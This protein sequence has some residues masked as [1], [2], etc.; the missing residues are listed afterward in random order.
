M[1]KNTGSSG[2]DKRTVT[3][4]PSARHF[5][6]LLALVCRNRGTLVL[7]LLATVV[8][9]CLHT[10]SVGVA[11][12][13]FK[14]LLEDE[15]IGG[16][17]DRTIAGG[18]LGVQFAPV[19]EF[20]TLRIVRVESGGAGRDAGLRP[21]D[22]LYDLD[23]GSAADLL[24]RIAAIE[25]GES[26]P[27]GV[28]SGAGPGHAPAREVRLTPGEPDLAAR[29]MRRAAAIVPS[30]SSGDRLR[31]LKYLLI[32]LVTIVIVANVFRYLGEV[33]IIKAVVLAMLGLRQELY[34]HTLR[35][36]LSYYAGRSTADVVS[37][38]VTDIQEIQR[39]LQTLFSKFLREPLRAVF[40]LG[41]AF[42]LDW[43]MTLTLLVV[44]P[45]TGL[46]FWRVGLRVKRSAGKLLKAYGDMVDALTQSLHGLRVVKTYTA[47]EQER[48]RLAA[49]DHRVYRQQLKLGKLQAFVSP[50]MET[51]VV[52]A[53][54]LLTLWL[55]GR[56]I[57]HQMA[58][59]KFATLGVAM[60]MLFDPLRK[61][62]DVYVR[63][64]RATAGAE[65]IFAVLDHPT[66][67]DDDA[68]CTDLSPLRNEIE[69]RDVSF[70][71]RGAEVPALSHINLTVRRGET[72]AIVGPNGSG[73]T[74]LVSMLPRL[75]LPD[76]GQIRYDGLDLREASLTS[77]RRQI[78]LVTQE[79]VVFA[80][81][82]AENIAYG[83]SSSE[84][85]R[86]RRAAERASADEFI[87][88]I[89]G[90]YEANLAERGTSL[91]GG[92]RQR[93]AI[94][95]AIFRD[96]PVLIFDEATSQ[97]DTES[98][99]KIQEA[100][101]ELAKDRTTLIIAHRLS[102]IEFVDRVVVMDA[103]RIVDTGTHRELIARCPLFRTL[104][105]TQFSAHTGPVQSETDPRDS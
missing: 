32:G 34:A 77:L 96:A 51:V 95:R 22:A 64:L 8:F 53:G 86:V 40:V 6:R 69:F 24:H 84:N 72:V 101:R 67:T 1:S 88:A 55:A 61:L 15:G 48:R 5:R 76:S 7:G 43:R 54:S 99:R 26:L 42:A 97:I 2:S 71:Y 83:S 20:D 28:N 27:V 25:T 30:V 31:A 78:G 41:L 103:G 85:G 81:T 56:V 14:V 3:G 35:L 19:D 89:P 80:G 98:E 16:W 50:A 91:S 66:E 87:R 92:Q 10:V 102:T 29:V 59:S 52:V 70:T 49:V 93:L 82:P 104:C 79:A 46:L 17:V 37:R 65:R 38:F 39:G 44:A 36:P 18:R 4:L 45:L 100:L 94:A 62:S 23:G 68:R 33:L 21:A 105:E 47:E 63:V 90:G 75:F 60:T 13:V 9:A 57:G 58:M 11:F 74:T 73:K 12:P